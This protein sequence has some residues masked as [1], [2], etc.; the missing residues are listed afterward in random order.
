MNEKGIEFYKK[1]FKIYVN[2]FY[3]INNYINKN[4]ELKENHTFR[5]C[6]NIVNISKSVKLNGK[7]LFIAELIALFHDIGRFEQFRDYNTFND[8]NSEDHAEM[9]VRILRRENILKELPPEIIEVIENVIQLHNKR[10]I[11]RSSDNSKIIYFS[12]LL[13]DSDKLDIL[14]VL[15]EYYSSDQIEK[16]PALDLDLPESDELSNSVENDI[17]NNKTINVNKLNSSVDYK[18]FLISWIFDINFNFTLKIIQKLKF[19]QKIFD[20]L[21]ENS[22]INKIRTHVEDYIKNKLKDN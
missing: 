14:K 2:Q 12:K 20:S 18:L 15:T 8:K 19:I 21:P 16:N 4:I 10:D 6:A 22:K 13:R 7:D 5:V 11:F 1:W 17:L 9:S 3:G